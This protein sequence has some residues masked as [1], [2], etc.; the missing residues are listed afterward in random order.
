[1]R[2]KNTTD[3]TRQDTAEYEK[4]EHDRTRLVR[5][6]QNMRRKNTTGQD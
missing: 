4:K 6:R 2:R 5:T 1:M 3:K